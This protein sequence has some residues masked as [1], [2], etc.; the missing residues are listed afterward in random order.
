MTRPAPLQPYTPGP[1][2]TTL[3]QLPSLLSRELLAI[4]TTL[5]GI[6]PM[7]PQPATV[8]PKVLMDG[9]IRL[10]R[11]PWWPAVGQSADGWV[12]YDLASTSWKF[13]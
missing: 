12:Y 8:A 9:M 11:T 4:S 2:T 5:A 1:P 3:D 10:A 13:L 7:T 6:L